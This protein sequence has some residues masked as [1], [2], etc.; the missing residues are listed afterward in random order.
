[1]LRVS[2]VAIAKEADRK[3]EFSPSRSDKSVHRV[4][5]EPE[6]QLGS[7]RSVVGNIRR[8]GGTPSIESI[9]TELSSMHSKQRAPALLALQRTHGNRYVQ[10]VVTGIQAKLKIGQPGNIYEQE[11]DRVAE[12]VMR[13]PEPLVQRQVEP[14][15]EE[16]EIIQPKPLAEEI[17]PLVQKQ[18][19]PEEG[20][21]DPIQTERASG[22]TPQVDHS[23]EAQIHHLRGGG[24]SLPAPTRA[25]FESRFGYD[26]SQVRVHSDSREAEA[27]EALN[28]R[29]FTIGQ[30][31]V[32][33]VGQYT[34]GTKEGQRLLTH[35]LTHVV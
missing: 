11:A 15:E 10:R 31:M 24:Q 25:F 19:G 9:A 32:F 26:F 30:D 18:I 33:G 22:Q 2:S 14:E 4:Q 1:M 34:I 28:A 29:A 7:L 5:N 20:G 12:Q 21:E 17:A 27:A 8:D 16:E 6:R 23:L 13:M 35:E 3:K